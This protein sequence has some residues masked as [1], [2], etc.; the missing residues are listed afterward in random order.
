M[1]RQ[2]HIY[3]LGLISTVLIDIVYFMWQTHSKGIIP[4][5]SA[6]TFVPDVFT[7]LLYFLI[8]SLVLGLIFPAFSK[9]LHLSKSEFFRKTIGV[10]L[11]TILLTIISDLLESV[12]W[13]G[14]SIYAC[15]FVILLVI[16]HRLMLGWML[17]KIFK[18][19]LLK[20]H[21]MKFQQTLGAITM[22]FVFAVICVVI[23]FNC[24]SL[25]ETAQNIMHKFS[26]AS[27]NYV[28]GVRNA[29]FLFEVNLSLLGMIADC[30]VLSLVYILS[31]CPKQ[32]VE[33]SGSKLFIQSIAVF[34][35]AAIICGMKMAI[36]PHSAL[37]HYNKSNNI[38]SHLLSEQAFSYDYCV[39]EVQQS[40]G[41][42]TANP[43]FCRT[44]GE[45]WFSDKLL[46]SFSKDG[47]LNAA[48][49]STVGNT[50]TIGSAFETLE[51]DGTKIAI[52][53]DAALAFVDDGEPICIPFE[54][55]NEQE[56]SELLI[57]FSFE[58]LRQ[59]RINYYEYCGEYLS[60][61]RPELL[62][63]FNQRYANGD[64]TATE[65]S[66]A[67]SLNLSYIENIAKT[68]R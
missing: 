51:I 4:Y 56:D 59:G 62:A 31:D 61:Y 24:I 53:S 57:N 37:S 49:N 8:Y 43:V 68:M 41:Y 63:P 12:I 40:S 36:L 67:R 15:I 47:R 10:F 64:F 35:V 23:A 30:Y 19:K 9:E 2:R 28:D 34:S 55:L 5:Y 38:S 3:I 50:I 16:G 54:E 66:N 58:M 48:I 42:D 25:Q 39:T 65:I 11:C 6:T 44:Y 22:S 52:L 18:I 27:T 33:R 45:I 60:K 13:K 1:S 29:S 14:I 26:I 46:Y 17:K 32:K 21:A 20:R 7:N